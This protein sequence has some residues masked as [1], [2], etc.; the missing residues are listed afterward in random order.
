MPIYEYQGQQYDISTDD[1]QEAKS[2]IL[3]HLGTSSEETSG[4]AAAGKSALENTLP[5]LGGLAAGGAAIA[6]GSPLI[7]ASGPFA[8]ATALALG[9]GG[10]LAGS[11]A[12]HAAQNAL[13][14]MIPDSI[15]EATGFGKEQRAQETEE[16]PY[17][18]F[19][20]QLAPNLLA[21]RPGAVAPIMNQ[22]GKQI[23]G[24][25]G[26]RVAMGGI[27]GAVEAGSELVNEGKID[28]LKVGMAT[29]MQGVAATPT[30]L[31]KKLMMTPKGVTHDPDQPI[32]GKDV[33]TEDA[34]NK[35]VFLDNSVS[36][37]KDTIAYHEGKI[38][39]MAAVVED[40]RSK[41]SISEAQVKAVE[42]LEAGIASRAKKIEE[43][44]AEI[45]SH[46]GQI[47][48]LSE[49]TGYPREQLLPAK[50]SQETS[51]ATLTSI[52]SQ[53]K[54]LELE[55]K[56]LSSKGA[57]LSIEQ[58]TRLSEIDAQYNTLADTAENLAS[59]A[60]GEDVA[61][62]PNDAVKAADSIK[63]AKETGTAPELPPISI[64]TVQGAGK[65]PP[66]NPKD[67][68]Q[69]I[70]TYR[71]DT[72][73]IGYHATNQFINSLI[74]I[75]LATAKRFISPWA[76]KNMFRNN[77]MVS[78]VGDMAV[79]ARHESTALQNELLYGKVTE[80]QFKSDFGSSPLKIMKL[81]KVAN[82]DGLLQ[83]IEKV[84]FKDLGNMI[85]GFVAAYRDGVSPWQNVDK[86]FP[87]I[88]Q[89]QKNLVR[90]IELVSTK[91]RDKVNSSINLTISHYCFRYFSRSWVNSSI[92]FW[93]WIAVIAGET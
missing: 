26:Q 6:A 71:T 75:P 72:G 60:F 30:A 89:E 1:P 76:F 10:G 34:M 31:G 44:H 54:D 61:P 3:K 23:L 17:A 42:K 4:L 21:F 16:H 64:D 73:D 2:K 13:T 65:I 83:A 52:E 33:N 18:S 67:T 87:A 32:P 63:A 5:S 46:N 24:S 85:D 91:M 93:R 90:V 74:N 39:E 84:K 53:M 41:P 38:E 14:G 51:E 27:G 82:Q 47:D 35:A 79:K 22:A 88:T 77:R 57:A 43:A 28:P 25:T 9:L 48:A 29:A 15:K 59:K 66:T 58:R 80:D 81:N 37:I 62:V 56:S 40:I 7:A 69:N 49:F 55:F 11:S 70:S 45:E 36:R 19:A 20:G 86:Y 78:D 12:I 8:P 92:W 68:L 50:A